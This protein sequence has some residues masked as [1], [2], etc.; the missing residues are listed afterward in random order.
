[1]I[2][3]THLMGHWGYLTIFLVIVL[4]NI[5]VPVPEEAVLVLAGLLI[6]KQTLWLPS[7]LIVGILSA[8]LGDNLG[9]WTGRRYGRAAIN[10]YGQR[11]LITSERLDAT[12]KFLDRHGQVGVFLARFIPGVRFMAG[13]LAG[14][15][16]MPFGRF[17]LAN[18][19]G[20]AVY[21]PLMVAFGYAV[22]LGFADY[23]Y[24]LEH[25]LADAEHIALGAIMIGMLISLAWRVSKAARLHGNK[26]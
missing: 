5:G 20:A 15:A 3:L 18:V 26:R 24:Q 2:D 22:G 8:V 21:V 19:A 4:G 25:F 23:I 11:L 6:W 16:G 7:V 10:H 14:T 1:M 13:P 17:F 12:R 9:Y